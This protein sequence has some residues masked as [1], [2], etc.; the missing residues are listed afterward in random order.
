VRHDPLRPG[1]PERNACEWS[2][3]F[4]RSLQRH[5]RHHL[6][7]RRPGRQRMES[8]PGIGLGRPVQR[9]LQG[10]DVGSYSAE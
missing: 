2:L 1:V 9:M 6:Q 3:G 4:Q 5:L 8:S 10:T 7:S